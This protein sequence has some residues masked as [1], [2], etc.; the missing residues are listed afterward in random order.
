MPVGMPLPNLQEIYSMNPGAF[1]QSQQLLGLGMQQQEQEL[2]SKQLANLFN[3]QN[4]PLKVQEQQIT[5]Q[6]SQ[7]RLPGILAESE[8]KARAEREANQLTPE[9]MSAARAKFLE[10]ASESDIAILESQ[11]RQMA[12]SSDPVKRKQG[13][14]LLGQTKGMLEEKQKHAQRLAVIREQGAQTRQTNQERP[15]PAARGGAMTGP[16]GKLS[17]EKAAVFYTQR[18]LEAAQSGDMEQAQAFKIMADQFNEKAV[19]LRASAAGQGQAG[20]V[21]IG[22]MGGVPVRTAPAAT[23]MQIP[24]MSPQAAPKVSS[25]LLQ[26]LPQ[27]SQDNGDGTFTLPDGRKVRP[28]Q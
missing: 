5:N 6:T 12:M 22:A 13:E 11:A 14:T 3:E 4:N 18:A 1:G 27:G 25:P 10:Q 24:G 15:Q 2:R 9:R 17:F 21:D 19:A 28:K 23:P 7:A 20:K 16:D 8:S 26:R